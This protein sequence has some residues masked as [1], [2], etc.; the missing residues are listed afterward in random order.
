ML[1]QLICLT[2]TLEEWCSNEIFM[3]LPFIL[4]AYMYFVTESFLM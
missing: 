1:W 3:H 4:S 2:R